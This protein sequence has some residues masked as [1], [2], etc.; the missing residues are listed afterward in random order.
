MLSAYF[1]D[2]AHK[3]T[4]LELLHERD[5]I[6]HAAQEELSRKFHIFDIECVDVLIGKPDTAEAGG[7]I[8]NLLEQLRLRQLSLEQ[9]ETYTKQVAAAEKLR[10]LNDAQATAQMQTEL[11]NSLVRVR[12]VE[13]EAEAQLAKAR[14][15][16]E[17]VVV[18]AEAESRR[19]ILAGRGEGARLLQEGLSEASVLL[20][21]IESFADPRL[22]ALSVA[23]QN[24]SRS[25]QPLVPE[26]VFVAPGGGV[27][28]SPSGAASATGGVMGMLLSLLVAEKSGFDLTDASNA[29]KTGLHDF[30]ETITKQAMENIQEAMAEGVGPIR[31][32]ESL[33]REGLNGAVVETT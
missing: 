26:R 27:D 13:N 19:N 5:R 9:M 8:E 2:V 30:V 6:Q 24:L 15:E 1:R 20:R 3:C 11:T 28:G 10:I 14:K 29:S 17:Q 21:K 32:P 22:Y 16:A 4:M 31:E 33:T 12:I 7:K 23:A 25:T 18:T